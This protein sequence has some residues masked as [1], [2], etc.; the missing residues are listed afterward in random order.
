M[1]RLTSSGEIGGA[2]VTNPQATSEWLRT[3]TIIT[4]EPNG[5]QHTAGASS[6]TGTGTSLRNFP[7]RTGDESW[8]RYV[9]FLLMWR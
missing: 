7:A 4:G 5:R 6:E 8:M 9:A 1:Y 3:C 2:Q